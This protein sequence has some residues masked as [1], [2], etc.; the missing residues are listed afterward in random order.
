MNPYSDP[1][2]TN[3]TKVEEAAV[4]YGTPFK[5]VHRARH[6]V[7]TPFVVDLLS[8]FHFSKQELALLID[9]S[10]KTLDRHFQGQKP[11]SGLQA[12]RLLRLG[13]LYLEGVAIF[14]NEL[15]F[16]KWLDTESIALD[17]SSPR[18]W[19]DTLQGIEMISDEMV[20]IQH[21]IFA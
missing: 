11:F 18:S 16:I 6:G 13:D 10:A 5:R 2:I 3:T 9:I 14:G 7:T 1:K 19:L 4:A 15:Q 17:S 20:R 21:G 8:K 12:E